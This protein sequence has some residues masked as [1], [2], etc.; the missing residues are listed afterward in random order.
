[1]NESLQRRID[2]IFDHLY[3]ESKIKNPEVISYEFS[4]ILHTG[5][6]IEKEGGIIPAFQDFLPLGTEGIFMDIL[7]KEELAKN[8][9]V[10]F[11]EMNSSWILFNKNDFIKFSVSDIYYI[12]SA[13]FDLRLTGRNIDILGDSLEIFRNHSIKSLGGQFFTDANVTKLALD[14]IEYNPL[15]GENFIDI[16][17]GTGG[18]LLAAINRTKN[19]LEDTN[20][21]NEGHLS[22]ISINLIHGKE[23]DKT[24]A[25][26][27]NRNIQTRLGTKHTYID[28]VDSLTLD[29]SYNNK[30]DC[31]ATNPPFG[32]KTTVKDYNILSKYELSRQINN[33]FIN[34]T[35]PDILFLEKNINIIKS[36]TGRLAIVLPYQI[37]SGP[38]AT[39]LRKWILQKCQILAVIDLPH[40][41]FQP[42]TGTKTCLLIVRK[43]KKVDNN[44]QDKNYKIFMSRPNWIGHDR[45]GNPIYKKNI[46]GSISSDILCDFAKVYDDW[47]KFRRGKTVNSDISFVIK[48]KLILDDEQLRLNA[49]YY[50]LSK[51]ELDGN[52][53]LL[54]K[55]LVMK[56]FY[57]GRFK[58][59]YVNS[60][61]NA[62]PFLGGANIT[63]HIISTKKFLSKNDPHIYQLIVH[64]GWILITRSGTTGIVSMVPKEWDGFAIS[65]HVIRIVPDSSKEDP[66]FLFAYL[67]TNLA[68]QQI[69]KSIFGS[70]ID[71]ISPESIGN[72]KI[73]SNI[74]KTIK[75]DIIESIK[76][77]E[78]TRNLS[79]VAYKQAMKIMNSN[80]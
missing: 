44:L 45:R 51:S 30:F 32:T 70:V 20:I 43:R 67:Q 74:D 79:I 14:L 47:S 66:F 60:N 8:L 7:D 52:N 77:Y 80:I 55:D 35:S 61:T 21:Y 37:L 69:H 50:S 71:E 5:I 39:Y 4:K 59:E 78:E 12:C 28:N 56:I 11:N 48:A 72:I 15:N 23:I 26:A 38:K 75:K 76:K 58:R 31:I 46:D 73:P 42:H 13:L 2:K 10:K 6:F 63:E 16:C 24:I 62:I 40:E 68:K 54:L 3:A 9:R 64:E 19:V 29:G 1:M 27:A 53:T 34:P 18:F 17:S 22:N 33:Q 49:L 41:T 65:E 25:D 36:E 57:P